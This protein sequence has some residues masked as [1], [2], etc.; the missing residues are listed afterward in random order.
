MTAD[1]VGK[2]LCV[3][4][5]SLLYASLGIDIRQLIASS[6]SCHA[7]V[8]NFRHVGSNASRSFNSPFMETSFESKIIDHNRYE[9]LKRKLHASLRSVL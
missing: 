7:G 5:A 8:A 9:M 1:S 3:Q 6:Q 4:T 2:P